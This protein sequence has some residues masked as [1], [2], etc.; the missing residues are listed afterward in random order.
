LT[1]AMGAGA[2]LAAPNERFRGIEI[3][4]GRRGRLKPAESVDE[5]TL[6]TSL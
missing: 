3:G 1:W 4:R 6:S 5:I 2:P